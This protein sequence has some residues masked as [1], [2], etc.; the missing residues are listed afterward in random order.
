MK[1]TQIDKTM[2]VVLGG[3][4]NGEDMFFIKLNVINTKKQDDDSKIRR[5]E[6]KYIPNTSFKDIVVLLDDPDWELIKITY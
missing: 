2:D 4:K 1:I 6:S 5:F 3:M